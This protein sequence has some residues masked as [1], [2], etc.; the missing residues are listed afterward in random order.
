[1]FQ[2]IVAQCIYI[3]P[4]GKVVLCYVLYIWFVLLRAICYVKSA[5][6]REFCFY[7]FVIGGTRS[8]KCSV[9]DDENNTMVSTCLNC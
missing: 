6:C 1:M 7:A 8:G 5:Y 4:V 9:K 2:L 3:N